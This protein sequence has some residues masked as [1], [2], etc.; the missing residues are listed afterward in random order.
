M[1][2][3]RPFL[4][5]VLCAAGA[6]T[7]RA[8]GTFVVRLGRDT[9]AVERVTATRTRLEAEAVVRQPRTT[10]RRA[11]VDFGPDGRPTR[12][13]VTL[14][15][16]DASGP[17]LVQRT[18]ATFTRDSVMVEIRRDTTTVT[19]RVAA[20]AGVIP[21]LAGAA[22][23]WAG[24]DLLAMR[25]KAG[26]ADSIAVPVWFVGNPST[27]TWSA[28]RL[29]RDSVWLYD[30]N[31]VFHARVDGD[32]HIV[33]AVPLSGTQQFTVERVASADIA[34]LT[35]AFAARDTQG[36]PLGLL[37]PRDTVRASIAGAAL[38]VDYGRPSKRGR[39]IFG[40]TIVPWGEVWRT[41]ANAATQFRTDRALELGGVVLQPGTYT[42]WT[43]PQPT[44]WKLLV[45]TQTGQWGTAHDPARDVYQLDM[46]VAALPQPVEQFTIAIAAEGPGGV[47]RMRWDTTE[48][49][50][51]FTVR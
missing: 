8:Q 34:A 5:I 27:S 48:A 31:D 43:I 41:G 39:A 21:I 6:G 7:A 45:N 51:P 38:W 22:S 49:S 18:V 50:I 36:Q 47:L 37:S 4:G 32:G 44:G 29:G 24:L 9:T 17:V 3:V 11:V 19:R 2:L 14:S 20:P 42:L 26:R 1:R 33:R 28:R 30:G 16:P 15:R 35:R 10:L 46:R 12:A 40:S 23:S 13:E 25:L